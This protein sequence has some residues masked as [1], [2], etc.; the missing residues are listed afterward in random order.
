MRRSGSAASGTPARARPRDPG[1]SRATGIRSKLPLR[2][3]MGAQDDDY[4]I[5][6]ITKRPLGEATCARPRRRGAAQPAPRGPGGAICD[7]ASRLAAGIQ[8]AGPPGRGSHRRRGAR[9]RPRPPRGSARPAAGDD[10]RRGRAG[11]RRCRVR[12]ARARRRLAARRRDRRRQPLRALWQR[13]RHRGAR[14]RDLRVFPG[15]RAADAARAAFEPPVLADAA[16]R[17][18]RVRLRH[19]G[20]QAWKAQQDP[21]L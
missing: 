19:A 5:V 9:D 3:R 10:R 1:G 11:F 21:L 8:S 6:E 18:P 16:G 13:A 15:S 14:A 7:R 4:V 12:G 17:A 2:D 20:E